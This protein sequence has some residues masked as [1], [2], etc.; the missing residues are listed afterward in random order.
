MMKKFINSLEPNES[1]RI[2]LLANVL[3][4]TTI[5][6]FEKDSVKGVNKVGVFLT[7]GP[8]DFESD[9]LPSIAFGFGEG[10]VYE[11]NY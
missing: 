7:N 2:E 6:L 9:T 4:T 3:P 11:W 5:I 10:E 8:K 1:G